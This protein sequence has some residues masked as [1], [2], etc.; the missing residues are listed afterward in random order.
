MMRVNRGASI[1]TGI[2]LFFWMTLLPA[3]LAEA[4]VTSPPNLT[5]EEEARPLTLKT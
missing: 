5:L 3:T 1:A 4:Q 2:A